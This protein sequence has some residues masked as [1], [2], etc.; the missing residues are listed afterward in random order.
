MQTLDS[1]KLA[2]VSGGLS[3]AEVATA[4]ALSGKT[5]VESLAGGYTGGGVDL[6][7]TLVNTAATFVGVYG[8]FTVYHL[9]TD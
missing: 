3:N 2:Q 4:A 8:G 1:K 7:T 6:T 5:L 9:L